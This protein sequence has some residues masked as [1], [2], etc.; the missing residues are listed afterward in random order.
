MA[1]MNPHECRSLYA[2]LVAHIVLTAGARHIVLDSYDLLVE[3]HALQSYKPGT[4]C[5]DVE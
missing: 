1:M 3:W 5:C 4:T 2:M